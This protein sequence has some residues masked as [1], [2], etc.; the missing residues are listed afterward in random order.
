MKTL[1][2]SKEGLAAYLIEEDAPETLVTHAKQ[3]DQELI[4]GEYLQRGG[5]D[6]RPAA[7]MPGVAID[8]SSRR[9][10]RFAVFLRKLHSGMISS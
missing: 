4:V 9:R 3:P 5:A 6:G 2:L 8:R 7:F 10:K 1:S